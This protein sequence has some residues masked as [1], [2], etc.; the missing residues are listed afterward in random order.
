M[1][2]L[3]RVVRVVAATL[4]TAGIFAGTASAADTVVA[5]HSPTIIQMDTGWT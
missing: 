2:T 3:K 1:S 4:L 5:K